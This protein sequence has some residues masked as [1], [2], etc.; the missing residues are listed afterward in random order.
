MA[1]KISHI[2]IPV[3]NAEEMKK[4]GDFFVNVI[5]LHVRDVGGLMGIGGVATGVDTWAESG[6]RKP[7][8]ILH[9]LDDFGTFVDIVLYEGRPVSFAKGVGSGKGFALA[10]QVPDI[11]K[12]WDKMKKYPV[13][14]TNDPMPYSD[15][16]EPFVSAGKEPWMG[17]LFAF[18]ALNM[19][20]VSEDGEEQ[21]IELCEMKKK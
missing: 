17:E 20:R 1:V 5:G 11:K 4:A 10:F 19:G 18:C 8:R 7:D 14:P 15:K 6:L 2:V 21:V 3:K 16:P 12:T 13:K 9:L